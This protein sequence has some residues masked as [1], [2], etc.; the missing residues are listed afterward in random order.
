MTVAIAIFAASFALMLLHDWLYRRPGYQRLLTTPGRV[1]TDKAAG[2]LFLACL[3]GAVLAMT[4]IEVASGVIKGV[5]LGVIQRVD[6]PVWFW[7]IVVIMGL[8]STGMLVWNLVD[9]VRALKPSPD[10]NGKSS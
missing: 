5:R 2:P 8:A 1:R 9:F 6:H 7:L 10:V 3:G 4:V